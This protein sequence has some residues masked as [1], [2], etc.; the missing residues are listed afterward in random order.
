MRRRE[1]ITTLYAP[2]GPKQ[3]DRGR[4]TKLLCSNRFRISWPTSWAGKRRT[5]FS[6]IPALCLTFLFLNGC[7]SSDVQEISEASKKALIQRKVDVKAGT[8]KSTKAGR[9]PSTR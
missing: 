2:E 9:E 6:S 4:C 3:T 1:L 7:G 8:A 5:R